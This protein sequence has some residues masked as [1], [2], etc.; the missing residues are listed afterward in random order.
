MKIRTLIHELQKFEPEMQISVEWG[1]HGVGIVE[2]TSNLVPSDPKDQR[3]ERIHRRPGDWA[4]IKVDVEH[5]DAWDYGHD[6]QQGGA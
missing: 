1:C 2:V 6:E 5:D 4:I 3:G